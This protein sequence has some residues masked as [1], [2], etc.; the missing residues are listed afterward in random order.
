[1]ADSKSMVAVEFNGPSH[2][3]T[4]MEDMEGGEN[5]EKDEDDEDDEDDDENDGEDDET[6]EDQKPGSRRRRGGQA[7]A[8]RANRM[9]APEPSVDV[10][11]G[12][13]MNGSTHFKIRLLRAMGWRV[14]SIDYRDWERA[15]AVFDSV[16]T[17]AESA[18]HAFLRAAMAGVGV[19]TRRA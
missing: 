1:M 8:T 14:V 19:T 17:G 18:R 12:V 13:G 9:V 16:D 5:D 10:Y 3:T 2:F 6:E 15:R 7:A 11:D 4:N